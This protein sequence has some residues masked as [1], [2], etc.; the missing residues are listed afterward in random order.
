MKNKELHDNTI[1]TDENFGQRT[2]F[3]DD[4][5]L[6]NTESISRQFWVTSFMTQCL[7]L[8]FIFYLCSNSQSV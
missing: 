7:Y 8:P 6:I 5:N 2:I 1:M 4:G 3:D